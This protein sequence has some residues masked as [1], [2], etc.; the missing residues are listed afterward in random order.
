MV[1]HNIELFPGKG[2]Q[3]A[4][5]AGTFAQILGK[6]DG[7]VSIQLASGL[8]RLLNERCIA[9]LG[10]VSNPE[11]F[12]YI[13]GKAGINRWLGYRPTVKG[14]A[15]NPIDH[16]HGGRTRGGR[17]PVTPWGKITHGKKTVNKK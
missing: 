15:M 5:S 1:I 12:N 17:I 14:E 9:T 13:A 7:K 10:K 11:Y 8:I 4:R 2:G 16:P 6:K 3:L